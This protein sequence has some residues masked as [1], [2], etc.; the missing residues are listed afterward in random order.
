MTAKKTKG[1]FNLFGSVSKDIYLDNKILNTLVFALIIYISY[2]YVSDPDLSKWDK[3]VTTKFVAYITNVN[4]FIPSLGFVVL[5][6][7]PSFEARFSKAL[8]EPRED[9]ENSQLETM[10]NHF[11]FIILW[12]VVNVVVC[13]FYLLIPDLPISCSC[14]ILEIAKIFRTLIW[15]ISYGVLFE[16]LRAIHTMYMLILINNKFRK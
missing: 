6:L 7:F 9:E 13:G 10:L 4:I 16:T 2:F 1:V 12:S 14:I 5:A 11:V 3:D 8:E 15:L